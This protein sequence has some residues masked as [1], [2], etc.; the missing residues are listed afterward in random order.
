MPDLLLDERAVRKPDKHPQVFEQF[1]ALA[2]GESFVLINNH[3]PSTS[4]R[5]S[6]PTIRESS[7]GSIYSEAPSGGR[8]G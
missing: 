4:A 1:N 3:D 5:S 2:V 7:A 8:C 6:R